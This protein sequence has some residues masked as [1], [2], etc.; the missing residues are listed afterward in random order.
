MF[1][2]FV[3]ELGRKQV[4]KM[5]DIQPQTLRRWL[6]GRGAI[7]RM[8][9]MAIYWETQYGKSLI[10]TDQ[11]NE[12]RI[13]YRRICILQE[14]FQRAKEIVTGLRRLQTGTANEAIFEELACFPELPP[15]TYGAIPPRLIGSHPEADKPRIPTPKVPAKPSAGAKADVIDG[16]K[17]LL[18]CLIGQPEV[19]RP[20]HPLNCPVF[21]WWKWYPQQ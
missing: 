14:Q 8:A 17:E 2:F 21:H 15:D 5:L 13:L 6:N 20:V 12:I 9:M 10:H 1:R 18:H 16:L 11:V 7:P 4:C 19:F 3:E